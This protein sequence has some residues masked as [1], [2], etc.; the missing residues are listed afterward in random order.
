M[1]SLTDKL[2]VSALLLVATVGATQAQGYERLNVAETAVYTVKGGDVN[3]TLKKQSDVIAETAATEQTMAVEFSQM[4]KW[5]RDYYRYLKTVE[6]YAEKLQQGV[7]LYADGVELLH[8]VHLLRKA[9][10]IN[11]EGIAATISMNSVYSEVATE[12]VKV[13]HLLR[14]TVAKGGSGNMISGAERT[15]L[16]WMLEEEIERLNDK[17]KKMAASIRFYR[18]ID[19]W[20]MATTGIIKKD[21]KHIADDAHDRWKWI[22]TSYGYK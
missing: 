4:T 12:M 10:R 6:G 20:N 18:L 21:I 9:I 3:K 11:P 16:V 2:V 22:V 17:V 5:Q 8:N 7:T 14:Y 15:R 1:K 19:V 13:Y